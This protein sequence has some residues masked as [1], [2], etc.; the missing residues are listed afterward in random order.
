MRFDDKGIVLSTRS[1]GE[2]GT[3]VTMLTCDHGLYRGLLR[4]SQRYRSFLEPGSFL[5]VTWN[6]RLADHLGSWSIDPL[7]SPLSYILH[8]PVAL[9]T[10]NS[11][12]HLTEK[13]LPEREPQTTCFTSLF[14]L[15]KMF[16]TD[17]WLPAYCH[18]ECDLI[19]AT[20]LQ[21]DFSRC[22]VTGE[23]TGL[24]YV[25]PRSGRAVSKD[26][27]EEY[28]DRLIPLP[29]FLCRS[30]DSILPK[31]EDILTALALTGY[32]LERYVL[33]PHSLK[34]P[35]VRERLLEILKQNFMTH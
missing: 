2:D 31:K 22:A 16:E 5:A 26:I 4:S 33:S 29:S 1:C 19:R 35:Q 27:G 25:S 3:I 15:M 13:F 6:A 14:T 8:Q 34:M 12:C 9:Q 17:C 10:L 28:K 21:L 7:S 20:G 24:V 11:A 23:R 18:F 30:V 32:F